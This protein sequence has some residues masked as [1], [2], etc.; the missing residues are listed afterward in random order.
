MKVIEVDERIAF[1][2]PLVG[3]TVSYFRLRKP[4]IVRL[5]S[6]RTARRRGEMGHCDVDGEIVLEGPPS[7]H[8]PLWV[9]AHELAHLRV[10][11]HGPRHREMAARILEWWSRSGQRR[12]FRA[13]PTAWR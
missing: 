7:N 13:I 4:P 8:L 10:W 9:L 5:E 11:N 12:L 2:G 6:A 1:L 3:A